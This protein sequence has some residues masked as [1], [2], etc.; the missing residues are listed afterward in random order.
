MNR[1]LPNLIIFGA[2]KAGSSSL[3]WFLNGHPDVFM[4]TPKELGFFLPDRNWKRGVDWYADH[5]ASPAATHAVVR[6]E[7]TPNYGRG[8]RYRGDPERM[9]TILPHD[10]RFICIVRHP[11][12]RMISEYHHR[13]S[14]GTETRDIDEALRDINLYHEWSRYHEQV[15]RFTEVFGLEKTLILIA[16]RLFA[17]EDSEVTRLARFLQLNPAP[18][19]G[20]SFKHENVTA[21]RAVRARSI[22]RLARKEFY[23]RLS[24]STPPS[25]RRAWRKATSS[26]YSREQR[27]RLPSETT[28]KWVSATLEDDT[29]RLRTLLNDEIPE[30][31]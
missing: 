31:G 2:T 16:E 6:G 17:N 20:R 25:F 18:L 30:W 9:A 12:E 23:R 27:N 28:I 22:R 11:V 10:A 24:R 3:H 15:S 4:S 19:I 14:N 7:T 13:R 5:F 1:S 21:N 29:D 26:A 8:W